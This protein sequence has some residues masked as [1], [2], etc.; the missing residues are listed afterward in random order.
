MKKETTNLKVLRQIGSPAPL[1]AHA[2]EAEERRLD[3]Q[4]FRCEGRI[5]AIEFR[6]SASGSLALLLRR[7]ARAADDD[8]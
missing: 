8:H 5:P 6:R 2:K 4:S 3:G 7:C 1:T